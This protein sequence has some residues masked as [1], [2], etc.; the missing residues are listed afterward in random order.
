MV[1]CIFCF[2]VESFYVALFV[3]S[4]FITTGSGFFAM[5]ALKPLLDNSNIFS[6]LRVGIYSLSFIHF[7]SIQKF[8]VLSMMSDF[9]LKLGHF[10][11]MLLNIGSYLT[12]VLAGFLLTPFWQRK[13]Y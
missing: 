1:L 7:Y 8:L 6:Y 9:Q 12:C 10:C 2:F 11:V 3:S 5:A 13:K 4:I